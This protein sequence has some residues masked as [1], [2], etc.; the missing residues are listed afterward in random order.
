MRQRSEMLA[1]ATRRGLI[2][3][4]EAARAIYVW[5]HRRGSRRREV[6]LH[7]LGE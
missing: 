1:V 6:V 2:E 5:E 4:T 3:I 7:V